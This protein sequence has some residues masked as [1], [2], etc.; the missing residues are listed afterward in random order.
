[1]LL[2]PGYT[3]PTWIPSSTVFQVIHV[4]FGECLEPVRQVWQ[5]LRLDLCCTMKAMA[6]LSGLVGFCFDPSCGVCIGSRLARWRA[7][8]GLIGRPCRSLCKITGIFERVAWDI[9]VWVPALRLWP[10]QSVGV[11]RVGLVHRCPGSS[12]HRRVQLRCLE[13]QI[14]VKGAGIPSFPPRDTEVRKK[15]V[16]LSRIALKTRK[17]TSSFDPMFVCRG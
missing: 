5:Q 14:C 3:Q 7:N 13:V 1:M 10:V 8:I 11:L 12:R 4:N 16:T 15:S 17:E 2:A 9:I 6:A